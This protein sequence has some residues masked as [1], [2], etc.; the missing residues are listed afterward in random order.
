MLFLLPFDYHARISERLSYHEQKLL[1]DGRI[2]AHHVLLLFEQTDSTESSIICRAVESAL[3][4]GYYHNK[5]KQYY[6]CEWKIDAFTDIEPHATAQDI[7][8]LE[9]SIYGPFEIP[10]DIELISPS[11]LIPFSWYRML[12]RMNRS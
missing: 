3:L 5:T 10:A 1:I 7:A 2:K 6:I 4:A 9:D 12:A 11:N 8:L